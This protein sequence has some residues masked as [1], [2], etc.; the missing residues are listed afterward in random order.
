[1]STSSTSQNLET[2]S[3]TTHTPTS[4][5]P[6]SKLRSFKSTDNQIIELDF[7]W[8]S[9]IDDMQ[10]DVSN[11]H[12]P[13]SVDLTSSQLQALKT[14]SETGT[15][16]NIKDLLT[17]ADYFQIED[18]PKDWLQL[19]RKED[20]FRNTITSNSS[21][22][23]PDPYTNLVELTPSLLDEI[24]SSNPIHEPKNNCILTSTR[25]KQS[26]SLTHLFTKICPNWLTTALGAGFKTA[27]GTGG[28]F[29][30]GGSVV[31]RLLHN[32]EP[33]DFDLF[34]YGCTPDEAKVFIDRVLV[35]NIPW[36]NN[37]DSTVTRNKFTITRGEVQFILRLYKTP[38]E[39]LSGFDIDS[40]KVGFDGT[41]VWMTET[42]LWSWRTRTN[43]VDFSRMSPS[44]EFRLSK[45]FLR[46]FCV[47]VPFMDLRRSK[48]YMLQNV[49]H[50]V[51]NQPHLKKEWPTALSKILFMCYT[52]KIRQ[53][54][55]DCDYDPDWS[56]RKL[57][58]LRM[59]QSENQTNYI[60]N[61]LGK[62]VAVVAK[63]DTSV[64]LMVTTQKLE[65][66]KKFR[67][68]LTED[69]MDLPYEIEFM[70]FNPGQQGSGSFNPIVLRDKSL[71]Y[72]GELYD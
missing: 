14:Y 65:I 18:A 10:E 62:I 13:I 52:G 54:V 66:E 44:Y 24:L 4:T 70:S 25:F 45:Y 20:Q 32:S 19:K 2:P 28:V 16:L 57:E 3:S 63:I 50:R 34:F 42:A 49:L 11:T 41:K 33:K 56:I 61:S 53:T 21:D 68:V 55:G 8:D 59:K 5:S 26:K 17:A 39:I 38:A 47:H 36:Q 43:I 9:I 67:F 12:E 72:V 51:T 15:V 46:G 48:L 31:Q 40:C 69:E 71:W 58:I 60:R 30:A 7:K 23:L 1:M 6:A 29:L 35:T 27:S 37:K 22:I 64:G